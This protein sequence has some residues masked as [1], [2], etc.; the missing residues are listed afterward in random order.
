MDRCGATEE[1]V[2]KKLSQLLTG[3]RG[4]RGE[5]EE[6]IGSKKETFQS[7]TDTSVSAEV[8]DFT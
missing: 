1:D 2:G 7:C 5:I 6:R 3:E 4:E 8:M